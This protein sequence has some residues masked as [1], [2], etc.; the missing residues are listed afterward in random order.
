MILWV[1]TNICSCIPI[2][3]IILN[4]CITSRSPSFSF[5]GKFPCPYLNLATIDVLSVT[6]VLP[7]LELHRKEMSQYIVFAVALTLCIMPLKWIHLLFPVSVVCFFLFICSCTSWW[8][9]WVVHSF[10]LLWIKLLRI[11]GQ[12]FLPEHVFH[13]SWGKYLWDC[14]TIE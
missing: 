11:F 5:A 4:V 3:I 1:L 2:T 12:Q 9:T 13:F 14:W 8:T 10:W 6:I 7:L